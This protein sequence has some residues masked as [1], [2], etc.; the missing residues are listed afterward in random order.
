MRDATWRRFAIARW[1]RAE[2]TLLTRLSLVMLGSALGGALRYGVAEWA[3]GLRGPWTPAG[4]DTA[5]F[6]IGILIVN[7]LGSLLLGLI[8][9]LLAN[10]VSSGAA[11]LRL[12]LAVGLC[13]G[14]TTF[15][16]FS[17]DTVRLLQSGAPGV[18]AANV[19]LSLVLGVAGC[20]AGLALAGTF[21]RP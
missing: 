11:Q 6:P 8:V 21:A 12:L 5:A 2:V 16:T 17:L 4:P 13:G 7:V 15:S 20:G 1:R 3:Q 9:G 19:A 10:D 14:F 18:A